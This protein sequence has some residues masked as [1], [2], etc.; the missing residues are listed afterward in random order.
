MREGMATYPSPFPC[1]PVGRLGTWLLEV[2]GLND[3]WFLDTLTLVVLQGDLF[4]RTDTAD[5]DDCPL[6]VA[7]GATCDRAVLPWT[8]PPSETYNTCPFLCE[9]IIANQY[10]CFYLFNM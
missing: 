6:V 7:V 9:L 2:T 10:T 5:T 3:R 4:I 1:L 8:H